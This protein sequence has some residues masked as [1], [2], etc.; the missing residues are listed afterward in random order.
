MLRTNPS[1]LN[2]WWLNSP[3]PNGSGVRFVA[4]PAAGAF[5]AMPLT[6][7][8]NGHPLWLI[9][10]GVMDFGTVV[11][12]TLWS[13]GNTTGLRQYVVASLQ[14]PIFFIQEDGSL[15]LSLGDAAGG[16][17]DSLRDA[18]RQALLGGGHTTTIRILVC[19]R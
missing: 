6:Q 15:G 17:C 18:Q 7:D 14:L 8:L 19:T 2:Q 9:D 16:N 10:Y 5:P 11:P 13:P 1:S 4:R 3:A 12:Q